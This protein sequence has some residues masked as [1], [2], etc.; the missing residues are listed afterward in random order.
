MPDQFEEIRKARRKSIKRT[1]CQFENSAEN[2]QVYDLSIKGFSFLCNKKNCFF[3]KDLQLNHIVFKDSEGKKIIEASGTVVYAKAIDHS[4]MKIGASFVKNRIVHSILG[5]IRAP[6]YMPTIRMNA[7]IRNIEDALA[8]PIMGFVID[9]TP[10][11]T[12]LSF[13]DLLPLGIELGDAVHLTIESKGNILIDDMA[14]IIRKKADSSELILQFCRKFLDIPYIKTISEAI[15]DQKETLAFL[16]EL[17]PFQSVSEPFKALVSDWRMYLARLKQKLDGENMKNTYQEEHEQIY[18]LKG[19]EEDV[20]KS[21]TTF[22]SRLNEITDPIGKPENL[23][24]KKYFREN[25]APFLRSSPFVAS[26]IDKDRGYAGNYEII[27]QLFE[28]PYRGETLFA[29]LINRLTLDLDAVSAHQDRIHFLHETISQLYQKSEGPF[30][31]YALGSGPGEEILRFV[32]KT[33]FSP[34]KPLL[35]ALLDMDAFALIDFKDHIQYLDLSHVELIT[36]NRNLLNILA[37]RDEDPIGTKFSLT[38]CAG[39]FDYFSQKVCKR[40]VEYMIE[41]TLPGGSLIVTNVHKNCFSRAFMDYGGEWEL[42]LRDEKEM[43][44]MAPQGM[45]HEIFWDEKRANIYLRI[46]MPS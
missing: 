6:R 15:T 40:I 14:N 8:P 13:P 36:L 46:H 26:V 37:G 18:F 38:Y 2:Y 19:I 17:T 22:I 42:I 21:M 32:E 5:K 45:A 33:P 11:A 27:K 24:Y 43:L 12:R 7:T 28:N 29:K 4:T 34:E 20:I 31:L 35:A 3:D 16:E 30:S 44:D 41:H 39:M 25:M 23:P 1:S 9:Y 10:T